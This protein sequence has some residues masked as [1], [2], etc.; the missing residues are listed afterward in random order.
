[1]L[2]SIFT[3]YTRNQKIVNANSIISIEDL[4]SAKSKEFL[5]KFQSAV[6]PMCE[7]NPSFLIT[8]N[9]GNEE[10]I[11]DVGAKGKFVLKTDHEIQRLNLSTPISGVFQY[12]YDNATGEWLCEVDNHDIRGLITRDLIRYFRGCPSF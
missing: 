2:S 7:V 6:Q 3:P 1:M 12:K 4:F 9:E 11:L 8:N 5:I 10:V